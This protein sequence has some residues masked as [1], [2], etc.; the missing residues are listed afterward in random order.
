MTVCGHKFYLIV[1][2]DLGCVQ[3]IWANPTAFQ[4]P[5]AGIHGNYMTLHSKNRCVE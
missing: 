1:S 2:A 3:D 4:P 5:K